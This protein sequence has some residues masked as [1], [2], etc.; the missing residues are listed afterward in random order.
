M[1]IE[2]N[3]RKVK[4]EK[5][6]EVMLARR[7]SVPWERIVGGATALVRY[8]KTRVNAKNEMAPNTAESLVEPSS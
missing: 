7:E 2:D 4:Q 8:R 6:P 1:R 5:R 3:G